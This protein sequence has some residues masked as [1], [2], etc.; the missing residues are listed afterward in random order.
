MD[1]QLECKLIDSVTT[2]T[3]NDKLTYQR[4][5][6][7]FKKNKE[8]DT[9]LIFT[10]EYQAEN[11]TI[12]NEEEEKREMVQAISFLYFAYEPRYWYWE[13][14]ETARRLIL[15][16]V[17]SAFFRGE[18][19]QATLAVFLSV[20]F[21][22]LYSAAAPYESDKADIMAETGQIAIFITFFC[23][24]IHQNQLL[25]DGDGGN[26]EDGSDESCENIGIFIG[27]LLV[28]TNLGVVVLEVYNIIVEQL[29]S[30]GLLDEAGEEGDEE[31]EEEEEEDGEVNKTFWGFMKTIAKALGCINILR[32]LL[33]LL[34][35]LGNDYQVY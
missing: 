2:A 29:V 4:K 30:A 16:A 24:L 9:P 19:S 35:L 33:H 26:S 17:I 27:I 31:E 15:T 8:N 22:K 11:A 10:I 34:Q 23:A 1:G 21:I 20:L 32:N 14:I 28:I 13:I 25:C 6:A 12:D 3:G 18:S 7:Y 5:K